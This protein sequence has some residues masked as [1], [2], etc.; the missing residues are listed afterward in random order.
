MPPAP[1]FKS[2]KR[3]QDAVVQLAQ[4]S[5]CLVYHTYDSRR[6]TPGFP[7]LVILRDDLLIFAELKTEKGKLSKYQA[8]WLD[9]LKRWKQNP[10]AMAAFPSPP[11]ASI[12]LG[13]HH[14]DSGDRDVIKD[15]AARTQRHY[16]TFV[17]W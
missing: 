2:E 4:L 9:A 7:D 17:L 13:C 3:F 1:Q 11:M 6:S 8:N 16:P 14:R 12:R 5:G 10:I 15:L